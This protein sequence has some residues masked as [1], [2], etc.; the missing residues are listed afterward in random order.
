MSE[1][2]KLEFDRPWSPFFSNYV[3]QCVGYSVLEQKQQ[4]MFYIVPRYTDCVVFE[5]LLLQLDSVFYT[6]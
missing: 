6:L 3:Q 2:P 4:N 5:R 1:L